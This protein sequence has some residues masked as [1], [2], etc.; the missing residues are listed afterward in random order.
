MEPSKMMKVNEVSLSIKN[1]LGYLKKAGKLQ[2]FLLEISQQY[3]LQQ[4]IENLPEPTNAEIDQVSMEVRLQQQL[5]D[6]E[7]FQQWLRVNKT[8]YD[9]FRSQIIYRLKLEKLKTEIAA[10]KLQTTFEEQKPQLDRAVLSR[11]V[12][13]TPD[14]AQTLKNKLEDGADFTQLA[15]QYSV[16]DDAVIGGVMGPVTYG[17]M[18]PIIRENVSDAQPGKIIGPVQIEQRYC[19]LKVEKILPATL[20]DSLK[21]QLETQIFEQW[22]AEKLKS[23]NIELNVDL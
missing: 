7:K 9:D 19:L 8:T 12:V 21:K 6:A 18:P 16:V 11:I 5:T 17:T 10:P 13:D 20:D 2:P 23:T 22:L 4:E 15:K 3:L 14:L 1:C